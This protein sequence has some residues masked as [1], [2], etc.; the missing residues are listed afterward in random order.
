MLCIILAFSNKDIST[1][2]PSAC[3]GPS[4]FLLTKATLCSVQDSGNNREYGGTGLGLLICNSLVEMMGGEIGFESE[5][6][7]G[8]T[9]W[10]TC[11]ADKDPRAGRSL[12]DEQDLSA[13]PP[14]WKRWSILVVEDNAIDWRVICKMLQMVGIRVNRALNGIEAM[15]T[16]RTEEHD[17][18]FM[19][20]NMPKMDGYHTTAA[21]RKKGTTCPI[22]AFTASL[23]DED[24]VRCVKVGM[25]DYLGKPVTT[26][27]LQLILNKW[28]PKC[29]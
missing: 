29:S 18:I 23:L 24:V 8:S 25:D 21:I 28:L 13:S 17:L 19:D 1:H 20:L 3:L 15:V 2:G 7:H 4:S 26:K 12:L 10:F 6:G 11:V 5:E 16:L 14:C 27:A 9:F 22:I